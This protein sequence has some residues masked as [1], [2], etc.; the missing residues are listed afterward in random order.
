MRLINFLLVAAAALLASVEAAST[1]T[2]STQMKLSIVASPVA[3]QAVVGGNEK[4]FLRAVDKKK[5]ADEGDND[6][7]DDDDDVNEERGRPLFAKSLLDGAENN[8]DKLRR[9]MDLWKRNGYTAN[10]VAAK[11]G[12]DLDGALTQSRMNIYFKYAARLKGT[13]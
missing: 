4:R 1:A 2:A 10:D 11:L 5:Q 12:I 8:A 3:V 13:P 6:D 9:L 7:D